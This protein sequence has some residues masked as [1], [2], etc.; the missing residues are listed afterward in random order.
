M[1]ATETDYLTLPEVAER[2]RTS[3]ATVRYWRHVGTGP[4]GVRFGT[5]VLYP[6][7]E[8]VRFDRQLAEAAAG[9]KVLA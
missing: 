5:R 6:R 4:R 1:P 8:I 9:G 7:A 3:E 2:Y